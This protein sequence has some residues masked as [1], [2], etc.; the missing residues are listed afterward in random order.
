MDSKSFPQVNEVFP[1]SLYFRVFSYIMHT[2]EMSARSKSH[3][4]EK[5]LT[6]HKNNLSSAPVTYQPAKHLL[7]LM[8]P[9][10]KYGINRNAQQGTRLS[11]YKL[12][13]TK[14][15]YTLRLRNQSIG[16]KI[17]KTWQ[18][19]LQTGVASNR[20]KREKCLP[21]PSHIYSK[22]ALLY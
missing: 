11:L 18:Q 15:T 20:P 4:C 14:H 8:H 19:L 10:H 22:T 5:L 12:R 2:L 6:R 9:F 16:R 13:T 1:T 7:R 21:I 3:D 17:W